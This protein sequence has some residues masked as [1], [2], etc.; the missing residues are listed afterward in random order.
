[1][2]TEARIP[3]IAALAPIGGF[4]A[5][6]SAESF[7]STSELSA[8]LTPVG[9]FI[10]FLVWLTAT[11]VVLFAGF[12]L[13][14]AIRKRTLPSIAILFLFS[15]VAAI[16]FWPISQGPC[17]NPHF[18]PFGVGTASTAWALYCHSSLRVW[19]H[20]IADAF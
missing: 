12:L 5:Y 3:L 2:D 14:M 16:I 4:C 1:M 8:L 13:H 6:L 9:I 10:S 15:A 17:L 7:T 18:F 20:R 19:Q 11:G